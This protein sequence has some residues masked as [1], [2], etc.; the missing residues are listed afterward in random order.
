MSSFVDYRT[1]VVKK[2]KEELFNEKMSLDEFLGCMFLIKDIETKEKLSTYVLG[3]SVK[4]EG[5][6]DILNAEASKEADVVDEEIQKLIQ[7]LIKIDPKK[8][9]EAA[10][11]FAD[12]RPSVELFLEKYPE[13]NDKN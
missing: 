3:L 13:C 11:Y 1:S 10:K 7:K 5:L 6:K 2:L 4:F 9:Q 12:K 8:A